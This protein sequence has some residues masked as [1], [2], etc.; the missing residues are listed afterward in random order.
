MFGLLV[1]RPGCATYA[2]NF[3]SSN[4]GM[5][6]AGTMS[7][8]AGWCSWATLFSL[9]DWLLGSIPDQPSQTCQP[10]MIHGGML[11]LGS[12]R[13][14][15]PVEPDKIWGI[16][17]FLHVLRI[18]VQYSPAACTALLENRQYRAVSIMLDLVPAHVVLELKGKIFDT[19][20]AFCE[21][22]D[23]AGVG[24]EI[25]KLIWVHLERY[26]VLPT[27]SVDLNAIGGMGGWKKSRDIPAELEEVMLPARQYPATMVFVHPLKSLVRA[28]EIIP[29]NIGSGH[30]VLGTG[31]YLHFVLDNVLL[32]G[33]EQEYAG[34]A[35]QW[36]LPKASKT[37]LFNTVYSTSRA[38]FSSTFA[39]VPPMNPFCPF[40]LR[41]RLFDHV[42]L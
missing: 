7:T 17:A 20:A 4:G 28:P 6:R 15:L 2:Y 13:Q 25:V 3:L 18:A 21:V 12:S 41:T 35:D 24:Q 32:K 9:L 36:H 22:R 27:R 33:S 14:P 40:V 37:A 8:G 30:R 23:E 10:S 26:K 11:D 5:I 1:Q 34:P 29:D 39:P 19:L 38:L 31:P 16:K 42:T